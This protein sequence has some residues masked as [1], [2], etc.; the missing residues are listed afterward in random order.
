M[1]IVVGGALVPFRD[2][3]GDVRIRMIVSKLTGQNGRVQTVTEG[4]ELA[5]QNVHRVGTG[6][7]LV[8]RSAAAGRAVY[9]TVSNN[10]YGS[11]RS[12]HGT[13]AA[14]CEEQSQR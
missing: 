8:M 2:R 6:P 11:G 13:E 1:R 7:I 10:P 14:C 3:P 12:G 4:A 5:E 9:A